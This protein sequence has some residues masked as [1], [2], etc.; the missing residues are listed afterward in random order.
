MRRRELP[1]DESTAA[2]LRQQR[3]AFRAEFGRYPEG[4]DPVFFDPNLDEPTPFSDD[5]LEDMQREMIQIME[6]AGTPPQ[7]IHAYRRTGRLVSELNIHLLST[8]DLDE[9]NAATQEYFEWQKLAA[10]ALKAGTP[11]EIAYAIGRTGKVI[12]ETLDFLPDGTPTVSNDEDA[13]WIEAV[14]EYAGKHPKPLDPAFFQPRDPSKD[15][16]H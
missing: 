14:D 6:V 3:E 2:L 13:E 1:I 8:E 16:L 12:P 4:N 7:L 9:W 10:D 5:A 15:Q 11:P